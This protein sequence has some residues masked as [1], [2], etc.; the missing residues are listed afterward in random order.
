MLSTCANHICTAPTSTVCACDCL[1]LWTFS[2]SPHHSTAAQE[3]LLQISFVIPKRLRQIQH[4]WTA[5]ATYEIATMQQGRQIAHCRW[6]VWR[7]MET[8]EQRVL[9]SIRGL[10]LPLNYLNA[11]QTLKR[12][13][14]H[15][16]HFHE[17]VVLVFH[18]PA[19]PLQALQ[20]NTICYAV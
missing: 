2:K 3:I 18:I 20:M 16:S 13:I 6:S 9:M 11:M 7:P 10:V 17:T 15:L 4:L 19:D 8:D 5:R 14:F 12:H 1:S